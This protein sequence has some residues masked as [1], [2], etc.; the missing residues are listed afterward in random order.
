M[1]LIQLLNHLSKLLSKRACL[2]YTLLFFCNGGKKLLEENSLV[3]S[4]CIRLLIAAW[5]LT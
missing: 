3:R 1:L 2:E 5:L 4:L